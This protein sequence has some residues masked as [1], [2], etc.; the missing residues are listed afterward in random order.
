MRFMVKIIT[1]NIPYHSTFIPW[2]EPCILPKSSR[3]FSKVLS[4]EREFHVMFDVARM[5]RYQ[6]WNPEVL[7]SRYALH[8]PYRAPS[9]QEFIPNSA[10][11]CKYV[12]WEFLTIRITVQGWWGNLERHHHHSV[13][14]VSESPIIG[15]DPGS[16]CGFTRRSQTKFP[17]SYGLPCAYL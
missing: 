10:S 1:I 2:G 15:W 13:G 6:S 12:W 8:V 4:D 3:K 17:V 11:T 14:S 16:T 9:F 5:K 7:M